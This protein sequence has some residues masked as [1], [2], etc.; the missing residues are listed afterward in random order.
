[1]NGPVILVVGVLGWLMLFSCFA[2][3]ILIRRGIR[4]RNRRT[5]VL[6]IFLLVPLVFVVVILPFMGQLFL[7]AS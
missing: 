7:R 5:L 4:E 2:G 3:V 6:G 1:M